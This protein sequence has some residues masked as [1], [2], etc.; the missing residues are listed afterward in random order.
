MDYKSHTNLL[1]KQV[2]KVKYVFTL[3]TSYVMYKHNKINY[4]AH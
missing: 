1:F 2:S 4:A 3:Q